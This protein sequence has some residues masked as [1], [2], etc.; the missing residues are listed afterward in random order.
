MTRRIKPSELF[1][2]SKIES[3]RFDI[4][5][6]AHEFVEQF[7]GV[8]KFVQEYMH[9]FRTSKPGTIVRYRLFDGCMKVILRAAEANKPQTEIGNLSDDELQGALIAA[10]KLR[11]VPI[12]DEE[13][14]PTVVVP[15]EIDPEI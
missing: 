6:L 15:V 2:A 7:G 8:H 9:E 5:E 11:D 13:E 14:E 3:K 12:D 4:S 1:S 10:L